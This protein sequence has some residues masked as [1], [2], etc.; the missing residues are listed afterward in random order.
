MMQLIVVCSNTKGY[1]MAK[2]D[3]DWVT[4]T[5]ES[6]MEMISELIFPKHILNNDGIGILHGIHVCGNRIE[7]PAMERGKPVL[8]L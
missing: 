4:G 6:C 7:E 5:L 2:N 3:F 8:V 1:S